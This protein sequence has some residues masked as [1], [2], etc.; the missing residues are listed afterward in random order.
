L[1]GATIYLTIQAINGHQPRI[2]GDSIKT[3]SVEDAFFLEYVDVEGII[4]PISTIQV[5][6]MESGFVERIVAEEGA[7]L[8]AGDTILIISNPDLSRNIDDEMELWENSQRNYREQAI[9]M[10]QKSILLRQQALDAE[11]QLKSL[12]KKLAQSREEYQMGIKSKAELEVMEE[13]YEY[14]SKRT[15]LQMESLSHDSVSAILKHEMMNANRT[16]ADRKLQRMRQRTANL[17]VRATVSGQL[18]F[19]NATLGQQV[20][21]GSSI[22]KIKVL[23]NYKVSCQLS[24]YYIDR[25]SAGQPATIKYQDSTYNLKVSKVTPEV[26]NKNFECSLVFGSQKPGNLRLG[27]SYR[28]KIE[29]GQPES[30]VIIPRGDF[31]QS[32][33]GRWIYRLA[34]DGLSAEKVEIEIGRQNPQQYEILSGLR[35]GDRVIVSGY[36]KIRDSEKIVIE[37]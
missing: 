34:P 28:V 13:E 1:L 5:N 11:H 4:Q 3:A 27:K 22:C 20:S 19:L 14:Q 30:A 10:E 2:K 35:P 6:A 24:E 15:R 17:A 23:S 12:Y 9:E 16:S 29:L 8:N 32:T 21:S 31:Y 25:V 18:S 33:A 7:M 37:N 26:V 36:D